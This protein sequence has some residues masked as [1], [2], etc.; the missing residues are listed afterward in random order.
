MVKKHKIITL[1]SSADF[2]RELIE[3]GTKLE[4]M[5]FGVKLPLTA[6]KM[7][8]TGIYDAARY[9]TWFKNPQDYKKKALLIKGHFNKIRNA[10]AVLV[11][12][13][14]KKGISGYIGGNTLIE[15]AIAFDSKKPIYI[16]SRISK[17]SSLYEEVMGLRPIFINGNLSKISK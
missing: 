16:L 6:T 17:K 9:K 2:F 7:K 1:C 12:N 4:K 10:D 11:V 14:N 8:K 3:I 13:N 15:M 5:G